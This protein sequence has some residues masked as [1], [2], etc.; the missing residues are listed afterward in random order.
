MTFATRPCHGLLKPF[1]NPIPYGW[2]LL[3]YPSSS[4]HSGC[5]RHPVRI[6]LLFHAFLPGLPGYPATKIGMSFAIAFRSAWLKVAF[7]FFS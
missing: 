7:S 5:T 6:L 1:N 2:A 4:R 3:H